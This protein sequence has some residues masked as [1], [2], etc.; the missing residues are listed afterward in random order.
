ME[1]ATL[2]GLR[3][4]HE[5]GGF[6]RG[7]PTHSRLLRMSGRSQSRETPVTVGLGRRPLPCCCD[8]RTGALVRLRRSGNG[9]DQLPGVAARVEIPPRHGCAVTCG[10]FPTHSQKARMS[11]APGNYARGKTLSANRCLANFY[12]PTSSLTSS[13]NQ[14]HPVAMVLGVISSPHKPL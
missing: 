12:M 4:F 6:R 3:R 2:S 7:C 9:P 13:Y 11:G 5:H 10:V 1:E 14:N 8:P